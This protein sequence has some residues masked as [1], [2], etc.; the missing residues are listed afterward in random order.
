MNLN[1]Y[2]DFQ[3]AIALIKEEM[4]IIKWK[5]TLRRMNVMLN[6][7]NRKKKELDDMRHQSNSTSE[8]KKTLYEKY[9]I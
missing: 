6:L 8:F 1:I 7:M 9:S 4:Q 2:Y 3:K 5:A